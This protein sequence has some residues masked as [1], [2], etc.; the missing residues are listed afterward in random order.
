MVPSLSTELAEDRSW[1]GADYVLFMYTALGK[2]EE[3]LKA[4]VS[5]IAAAFKTQIWDP[6]MWSAKVVEAVVMAGKRTITEMEQ[7]VL[8]KA[9]NEKYDINIE[10]LLMLHNHL[11]PDLTD[12]DNNPDKEQVEN[13]LHFLLGICWTW[14]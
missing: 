13:A 14:V 3:Q 9:N 5:N 6:R 10:F 1:W 12:W 4:A 7:R 2:R 8:V 11:R